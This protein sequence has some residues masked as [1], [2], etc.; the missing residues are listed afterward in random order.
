MSQEPSKLEKQLQLPRR[1]LFRAIDE[2]EPKAPAPAIRQEKLAKASALIEPCKAA[3]PA[4][5]PQTPAEAPRKPVMGRPKRKGPA[6]WEV[7]GLS[8]SEWYRRK[9]QSGK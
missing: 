3:P 7:E 4:I 1:N 5:E 9:A 2:P 6:P 8:R